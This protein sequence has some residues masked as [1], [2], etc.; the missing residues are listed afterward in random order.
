MITNN[1]QD[2]QLSNEIKS[3]FKELNVLKHL[4]DAGTAKSFE[5]PAKD[6]I[7]HFLN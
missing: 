3:V 1:D 6:T 7:Y 4:R 2:K 5:F